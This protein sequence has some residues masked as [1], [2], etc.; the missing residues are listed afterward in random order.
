LGLIHHLFGSIKRRITRIVLVASAYLLVFTALTSRILFTPGLISHN[1]DWHIPAERQYLLTG[2]TNDLQAWSAHDF[3]F[4]KPY[5]YTLFQDLAY[6][7][8][9]YTG[10]SP[11]ILAKLLLILI[12]FLAS[13]FMFLFLRYELVINDRFDTAYFLPSLGGLSFGLSSSIFYWLHAGSFTVLFGSAFVPLVFWRAAA[14]RNAKTR[15][16]LLLFSFCLAILEIASISNFLITTFFLCV[17]FLIESRNVLKYFPLLL[18]PSFLISFGMFVQ[19]IVSPSETS[20]VGR[21]ISFENAPSVLSMLLATN[22]GDNRIAILSSPLTLKGVLI[23]FSYVIVGMTFVLFV[24][25]LLFKKKLNRSLLFCLIMYIVTLIFSAGSQ[26]LGPSAKIIYSFPPMI[27]LTSFEYYGTFISF[28][29]SALLFVLATSTRRNL[30]TRFGGFDK[31]LILTAGSAFVIGLLLFS[32]VLPWSSTDLGSAQMRSSPQGG[33][34]L[35]NPPTDYSIAMN[36]LASDNSSYNI[37]VVPMNMIFNFIPTDYQRTWYAVPG[38][39]SEPTLFNSLHGVVTADWSD[40][41]GTLIHVTYPY[42]SNSEVND[43]RTTLAKVLYTETLN[44]YPN[45]LSSLGIKYILIIKNTTSYIPA[46]WG[47]SYNETDMISYLNSLN[48]LSLLVNGPSVSLYKVNESNDQGTV[49]L[50]SSIRAFQYQAPT[51]KTLNQSIP[52][53]LSLNSSLA[54]SMPF[55]SRQVGDDEIQFNNISFTDGINFNGVN[56][57]IQVELPSVYF[58]RNLSLSALVSFRL[59]K[60]NAYNFIFS[61]YNRIVFWLD[62]NGNPWIEIKDQNQSWHSW[63]ISDFKIQPNLDYTA[64]IAINKG[65]IDVIINNQVTLEV[66][67]TFNVSSEMSPL[68]VGSNQN[69]GFFNGTIHFLNI[70]LANT[71]QFVN[72][73]YYIWSSEPNTVFVNSTQIR[74]NLDLATARISKIDFL[75][76]TRYQL[77]LQATGDFVI[78]FSQTYSVNWQMQISPTNSVSIVHTESDLGMNMWVVYSKNTHPQNYQIILVYR[79][80]QELFIGLTI[81]AITF[82]TFPVIFAIVSRRYV[83]HFLVKLLNRRH[84]PL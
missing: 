43:V 16:N 9:Y 38:S 84:K 24:L 17:Y 37:L 41:E 40:A 10:L 68:F 48:F 6:V 22:I 77:F 64:F 46:Q 65:L 27:F 35:F 13:F 57:Q 39:G 74:P 15:P 67:R 42:T 28:S 49:N 62:A 12:P 61:F 69:Y 75:S 72:P 1:W 3:G 34:D 19:I 8:F 83:A 47:V 21:I 2:A 70:Y 11:Q 82:M 63:K 55:S 54:S 66:P 20:S 56:S 60:L 32:Y 50:A 81:I 80:Q 4:P 44:D 58:Q 71:L 31:E 51:S 36:K 53:A 33:L 14:L 52:A 30:N 23:P 45:I 26:V 7:S 18:V 5:G 78:S 79:P 29:F 25:D 59:N 73:I 76:P